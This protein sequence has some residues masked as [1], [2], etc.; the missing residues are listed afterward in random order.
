MSSSSN[1]QD[2]SNGWEA[3]ANWFISIESSF[4]GAATVENWS[5]SLQPGQAILD[6]GCGFG[7]PYTQDLID[8]GVK[9]YGIDA[10][11]TL[12]QEYQKR[13]P[14]VLAECEAAEASPFFRRKFDGILSVGLIF[15][16]SPANQTLVLEKMAIALKERDKLLFSSPYQIC[17]WDDLSTGRKSMSLGR[18]KY[19]STLKKHGLSLIN[20]HTDEGENHYYD[21]QKNIPR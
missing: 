14:G 2:L 3:I 4:T 10:S 20:E 21:F 1:S 17:D 5:A 7:G 9:V 15:L 13:F 18:E 8:K 12:I 11:H 16:L 19:T 6:V